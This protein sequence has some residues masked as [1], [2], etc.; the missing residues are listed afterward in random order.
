MASVVATQVIAPSL[1]LGAFGTA[2]LSVGANMV[3]AKFT[4]GLMRG[5]DQSQVPNLLDIPVGSNSPGAPRIWACG[6][7]V[8]VPLHVMWQN[9]KEREQSLSQKGGSGI[10]QKRV[11]IDAALALNDRQTDSLRQLIGNGKLL[12]WKDRNLVEIQTS[13]MSAAA[14]GGNVVLSMADQSDPDFSE[15]FVIGNAVRLDF[16]VP[17]GGSPNL[18]GKRFRVSATTAHTSST[19]ST[20]TLTPIEGQ[21]VAGANL[22]GGT[23]WAPALV[24]RCDDIISPSSW[25]ATYASWGS[26]GQY[27]GRRLLIRAASGVVPDKHVPFDSVVKGNDVVQI[28]GVTGLPTG[29]TSGIVYHIRSDEIGLLINGSYPLNSNVS[30]ANTSSTDQLR[31]IPQNQP[32]FAGLFPPT[33]DPDAHFYTGT[34]TQGEDSII[35][36]VKGTGNVPA[37]RGMSYQ[38]VED[39]EVTQFGNALP[40]G[41]EAILDVDPGMNWQEAILAVMERAGLTASE[42]DVSGVDADPFGGIIVRGAA[43]TSTAIQPMLIAKQIV[44]QERDG[45]IAFYQIENADSV[46]I[47]NGAARTAFG[48]RLYGEQASDDKIARQNPSVED[49]PTSVG[50]R[51]QDPDNAYAAGYQHFGLRSPTGVDWQNHSDIDLSNLVLTRKEARNLAT[52]LL[53]RA[54]LNSTTV[55]FLLDA[56]YIDLLENDLVTFTDDDGNDLVCRV[57]QL[58]V[59][60][61]YIVSVRAVLEDTELA[62]VGS[63]IQTNLGNYTQPPVQPAAIEAVVL[64]IPALTPTDA[65]VPT[66][67]V[68]AGS[69]SGSWQGATVYESRDGGNSWVQIGS[70][71]IEATIGTHG[72]MASASPAETYGSTALT[73]DNS[74]T[75]T[76]DLTALGYTG[77]FVSCTTVEAEQAGRNWVAIEDLTTGRWE[78]AAF[79]TATQ[80]GTSTWEL[81][82]WLRGL[83]GTVVEAGETK[84]AGGRIVLLTD[85]DTFGLRRAVPDAPQGLSLLY[86]VVPTGASLAETESIGITPLWKSASPAPCRVLTKT[87]G[88]SPYDAEFE[89]ENWTR[90]PLPLGAVGPYGMD[91]SFEEYV[92]TIYDPT[93]NVARRVK[94][95]STRTVNG[96]AGSPN[97]RD[98]FVVYSA[99]E[100]TADGYAPSGSTSFVV[101]VQHVGDYGTSTSYKRTI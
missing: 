11:F 96:V 72:G 82:G 68:A 61:N 47:E 30:L 33:F 20:M 22:G 14:S 38:T 10:T 59:G 17:V 40:F 13:A 66:L 67:L 101:D 76:V 19:P 83:R 58:D 42:V 41:L 62:V 88:G 81:T 12:V 23:V 32:P 94:R 2:L 21:S 8:R 35:V 16:F 70:T 27:D 73:Y 36:N 6:N 63:P 60:A 9:T 44:T 45:D 65:Q 50:V 93:G 5:K 29:I 57:V 43:P 49:L 7:R 87:I 99:A 91:E 56:R 31:L 77:G 89:T 25:T 64:D 80:T 46:Q 4:S 85:W 90:Y 69:V 51:H 26:L 52:T 28:L 92:F 53:R 37:Y 15:V 74:T 95:I 39:F 100:Q 18:N 34:E 86:R 3:D 79:T 71:Q 1:G 84:P 78:I 97:L 55:E 54:W 24:E 75:L 98:R 48:T